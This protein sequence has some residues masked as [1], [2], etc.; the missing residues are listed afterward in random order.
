MVLSVLS[1]YDKPIVF[2][3]I[4]EKVKLYGLTNEY[5]NDESE[6][7]ALIKTLNR[8]SREGLVDISSFNFSRKGYRVTKDVLGYLAKLNIQDKLLQ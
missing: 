3:K 7:V 4:L 6:R 5:K 8:L 1:G 2:G